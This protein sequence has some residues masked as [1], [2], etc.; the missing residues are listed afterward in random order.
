MYSEMRVAEAAG[1]LLRVGAVLRVAAVLGILVVRRQLG[2]VVHKG[3][4][5]LVAP[6][7]DTRKT[8]AGS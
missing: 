4:G 2:T 5:R 1:G 8:R 7:D 3:F 6:V